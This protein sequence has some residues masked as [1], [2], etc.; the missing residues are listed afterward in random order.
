M[1]GWRKKSPRTCSLRSPGKRRALA[2][3]SSQHSLSKTIAGCLPRLNHA[4][5]PTLS[6]SKV[7]A[8]A[9]MGVFALTA[10]RA[11]LAPCMIILAIQK[12]PGWAF[13]ACLTVAFL[14]D[15]YDGVLARRFGVATPALRR[16]D[17]ITDDI[18]YLSTTWAAWLIYP[19]VMFQPFI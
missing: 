16:F 18:F 19:N 9:K 3:C 7:Q 4:A 17:S 6:E 15:I 1:L 2:D 13:V 11:A 14:S 5:S 12:A 10:L 8:T